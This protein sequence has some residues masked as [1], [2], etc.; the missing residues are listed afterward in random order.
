LQ[1][2]FGHFQRQLGSGLFAGAAAAA[3]AKHL[4][5]QLGHQ[6]FDFEFLAVRGAVGGDHVVLRQ[7][8]F[9]AAGIPAA[10]SWHPCPASAGRPIQDRDV[11]GADHIARR[12]EAAVEEDGAQQR[13]QRIGQDR[14]TAEAA[15]FQLAFAQAQELRQFQLLGDFKQRLLLDQV[16][17]QARQVALVDLQV[18]VV[19]D[20]GHHAVQDRVARNSSRS[21]CTLLWLRCVK[22]CCNRPASWNV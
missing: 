6:A 2:L 11:E 17:A 20:G 12:I 8:D 3:T 9:F 5:A 15:R 1:R 14:R 22:A 4:D 18:A 21:L 16:G 7:R 19:Q 13:F 10:A